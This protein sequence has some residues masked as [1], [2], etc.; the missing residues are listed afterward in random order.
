MASGGESPVSHIRNHLKEIL[1]YDSSNFF[2][3]QL[4]QDYLIQYQGRVDKVE[5]ALESLIEQYYEHANKNM[6]NFVKNIGGAADSSV[7]FFKLPFTKR[8][9]RRVSNFSDS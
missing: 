5:C 1:G 6:N 4:I 9:S 8:Q 3:D 7:N 2:S